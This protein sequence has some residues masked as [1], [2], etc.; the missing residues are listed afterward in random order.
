MALLEVTTLA[1]ATGPFWQ[2]D[3]VKPC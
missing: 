3:V 1:R 2:T